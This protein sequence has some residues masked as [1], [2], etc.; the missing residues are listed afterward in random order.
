M[1]EREGIVMT[2]EL[3]RTIWPFVTAIVNLLFIFAVFALRKTFATKQELS[4][5]KSDHHSLKNEHEQLVSKV[6]SLPGHQ[7][8]GELSIAMEEMRG[9]IKAVSGVLKE[10]K[11]M[12]NL[13]IE[14]KIQ[15]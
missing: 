8:I 6:M 2:L 1:S 9:E 14:S 12:L 11:Y 7:D 4:A 3:F 5:L 10:T 13:I 15:E